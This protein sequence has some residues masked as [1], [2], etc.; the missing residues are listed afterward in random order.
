M[1]CSVE[2]HDVFDRRGLVNTTDHNNNN[3]NNQRRTRPARQN[4]QDNATHLTISQR[5]LGS[6][7]VLRSEC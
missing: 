6:G 2:W 1:L 3:S 7:T 4:P 5:F